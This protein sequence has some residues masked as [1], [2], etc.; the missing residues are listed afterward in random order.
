MQDPSIFTVL[1]CQSHEKGT[2]IADFVIFPPRWVVQE[3]TF[4]LPYF[5][6]NCMSEFMGLVRGAYEAKEGGFV[7]GGAR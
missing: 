2:A 1:T 4:R 5:H 7:P 3:D 6:R